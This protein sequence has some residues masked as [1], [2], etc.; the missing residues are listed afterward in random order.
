MIDY[1]I[2][3]IF[4]IYTPLTLYFCKR[5]LNEYIKIINIKGIAGLAKRVINCIVIAITHYYWNVVGIIPYFMTTVFGSNFSNS[6]C[7]I[8][9]LQIN[10]KIK[11]NLIDKYKK[12]WV[13]LSADQSTVCFR[14]S[15]VY[16]KIFLRRC[17]LS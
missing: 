9:A 7:L 6:W 5:H 8:S 3:I 4:M 16:N 15:V 13:A 1:I 10:I 11:I 2:K 17:L 14:A 12:Y